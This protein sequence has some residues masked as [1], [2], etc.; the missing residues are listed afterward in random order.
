MH[1][2][3]ELLISLSAKK[4]LSLE[5]M[6]LF[7]KCGV[8]GL[9]WRIMNAVEMTSTFST[10][11]IVRGSYCYDCS[12]AD[13]WVVHNSATNFLWS[14]AHLGLSLNL[15]KWTVKWQSMCRSE[16]KVLKGIYKMYGQIP[17]QI[18]SHDD[19]K[20]N[21]RFLC[22]ELLLEGVHVLMPT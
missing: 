10:K 16:L 12:P 21:V 9:M 15:S 3:P 1:V 8:K 7:Q 19:A 13:L 11:F 18:W 20:D 5:G 17:M 2:K 6:S 4:R 14:V 22:L